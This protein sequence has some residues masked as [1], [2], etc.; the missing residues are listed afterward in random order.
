[1]SC[2][3]KSSR[4]TPADPCSSSGPRLWPVR[5]VSVGAEAGPGDVV[6]HRAVDLPPL[7]AV[8]SAAA[9]ARAPRARSRPGA[10]PRTRPARAGGRGGAVQATQVTSAKGS[11]ARPAGPE[12]DQEPLV[13]PDGAAAAG[14]GLVVGV[15]AVGAGDGGAVHGGQPAGANPAEMPCSHLVLVHWGPRPQALADK[16]ES[17]V[18]DLIHQLRGV[19]LPPPGARPTGRW[20]AAADRPRRP[21][22]LPGS[23]PGRGCPRPRGRRRAARPAGVLHGHG[24]RPPPIPRALRASRR[25]ARPGVAAG[26]PAGST[27]A[28]RSMSW[29]K[30]TTSPTPAGIQRK[31]RRV[32]WP[33]WGPAPAPARGGDCCPGSPSAAS[34]AS[35]AG[36]GSPAPRRAGP[37][38]P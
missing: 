1:M 20:P 21:P 13:A 6:P 30:A 36:P 37:S 14:Q 33:P 24:P 27:R 18:L 2:V 15:G 9:P 17:L 26:R 3:S 4:Q 35:L 34:P 28:P 23:A 16:A 25:L 8:P 10:P 31:V 12:V 22:P 7:G 38:R 29:G 11:P 32:R 5:W 19:V